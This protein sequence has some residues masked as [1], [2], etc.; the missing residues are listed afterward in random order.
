MSTLVLP[1]GVDVSDYKDFHATIREGEYMTRVEL[2]FESTKLVIFQDCFDNE[3]TD[4]VVF[5]TYHGEIMA[6]RSTC[7]LALSD[8]RLSDLQL[9]SL[10]WSIHHCFLVERSK[11]AKE[12]YKLK[13]PC[14]FRA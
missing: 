6:F 10:R 14:N 3:F 8:R 1:P 11:F 2:L 5:E 9:L 13:L 12:C 7:T 4:S